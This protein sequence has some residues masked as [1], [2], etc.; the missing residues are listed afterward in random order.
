MKFVTRRSGKNYNKKQ[1]IVLEAVKG[2]DVDDALKLIEDCKR[3]ILTYSKVSYPWDR[4][5]EKK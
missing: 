3:L 1:N 2:M 5:K 4:I